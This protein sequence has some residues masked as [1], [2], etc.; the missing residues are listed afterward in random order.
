M[1]GMG[2]PT[3]IASLIAYLCSEEA[4]YMTGNW[5]EVDGGPAPMVVLSS[6]RLRWRVFVQLRLMPSPSAET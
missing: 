2:R 6:M 3:E 4:G 1:A 5:I